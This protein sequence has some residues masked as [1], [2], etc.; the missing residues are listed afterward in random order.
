MTRGSNGPHE[1]TIIIPSANPKLDNSL[2]QRIPIPPKD[3][4]DYYFRPR[5]EFLTRGAAL[6][7]AQLV[8]P[9]YGVTTGTGHISS[10]RGSLASHLDSIGVTSTGAAAA[11]AAQQRL[12]SQAAIT[13]ITTVSISRLQAAGSKE[14]YGERRNPTIL[15]KSENQP[16]SLLHHL[17]HHRLDFYRIGSLYLLHV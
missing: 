5:G 3:M 8:T 16:A 14:K 12:A 11:V 17:D 4:D 2:K 10:A 13:G 7:S 6:A 1:G 9:D 15:R